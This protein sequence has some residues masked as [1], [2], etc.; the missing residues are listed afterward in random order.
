[1]SPNLSRATV[2]IWCE[3]SLVD[4]KVSERYVT[5]RNVAA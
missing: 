4:C 5:A 1:M 3:M 2:L